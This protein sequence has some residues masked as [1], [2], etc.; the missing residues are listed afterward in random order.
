[1]SLFRQG[2]ESSSFQLISLSLKIFLCQNFSFFF[3]F[4]P[5]FGI[6]TQFHLVFPCL[7]SVAFHTSCRHF[8]N[9]LSNWTSLNFYQN[10]FTQLKE[11]KKKK[12]KKA[13]KL[14]YS[15][16]N[17]KWFI[18]YRQ[19]KVRA[20]FRKTVSVCHVY[21]NLK[22]GFTC[23]ITVFFGTLK[24]GSLLINTLASNIC[25]KLQKHVPKWRRRFVKNS[26]R[27]FVKKLKILSSLDYPKMFK[28]C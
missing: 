8:M 4:Q 21:C 3:Y 20:V 5:I 10:H 28:F 7:L 16:W 17:L 6:F 1:M 22:L 2:C 24:D 23:R 18:G 14:D 19:L 13:V 11:K 9:L 15:I 25:F 26:W 27:L 12:K